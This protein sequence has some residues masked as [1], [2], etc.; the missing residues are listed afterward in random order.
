[1]LNLLKKQK[2]KWN[3]YSIFTVYTVYYGL[4]IQS[5]KKN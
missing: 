2:Y 1:M 4:K 3:T 5:L